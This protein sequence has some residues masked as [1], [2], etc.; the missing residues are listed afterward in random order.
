MLQR[1]NCTE[2]DKSAADMNEWSRRGARDVEK[3]AGI[4]NRELR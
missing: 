4:D 1:N 2:L 3:I